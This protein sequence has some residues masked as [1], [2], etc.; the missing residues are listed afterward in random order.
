M[1]QP[2]TRDLFIELAPW[3]ETGSL[4]PAADLLQLH[5]LNYQNPGCL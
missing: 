5:F 1:L 2:K 4:V 3:K